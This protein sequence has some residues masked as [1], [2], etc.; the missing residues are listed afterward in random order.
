LRA[1]LLRT[2][3]F[4]ALS[5]A[6]LLMVAAGAQG[7]TAASLERLAVSSS[8]GFP[9]QAGAERSD[10][11]FPSTGFRLKSSNGYRIFVVGL[12]EGFAAHHDIVGLRAETDGAFSTYVVR[13]HVTARR[14]RA[15]IGD[16][17][18]ID[19]SFHPHA[20]VRRVSPR[21]SRRHYKVRSGTWRGTIEFAGESGYTS[22]SAAQAKP[23]W[24]YGPAS[25][26]TA[27]SDPDGA[28]LNN[29]G[30]QTFFEAYQNGGP[31]TATQFSANEL[32]STRQ[33]G[34]SREVWTRGP[35]SAFTYNGRLTRARVEPPAPFAGSAIYKKTTRAGKGT[36]KGDL[37]ASFPGG[38]T[39][40][41]VGQRNAA[42]IQH[43][44]ITIV[45]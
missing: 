11:P 18:K 41:L 40:S 37:S 36:L 25:C 20:A 15:Q 17:G 32:E 26:E 16:L 29:S 7:S 28:W 39:V 6:A 13:G 38:P 1:V 42:Y 8:N 9:A 10:R 14:I 2:A 4:G 34:I 30:P 33:M 12:P 21:C 19:M 43:G 45:H 44:T 31:G 27:T 24:L 5:L 22:V 35:A 23:T 3:G